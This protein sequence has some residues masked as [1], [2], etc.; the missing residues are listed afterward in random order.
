VRQT[1]S[2]VMTDYI[3]PHK[4]VGFNQGWENVFKIVLM[5]VVIAYVEHKN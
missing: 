1:V 3:A 2:V 5:V 4:N